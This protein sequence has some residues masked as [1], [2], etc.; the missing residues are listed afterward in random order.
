VLTELEDRARALGYRRLVLETGVHQ[1]EAM[2]LY[3]TSGYTPM[4]PYGFYRNSPLSRCYAKALNPG[5][6]GAEVSSGRRAP[7]G[8][9][10]PGTRS[11]R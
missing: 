9:P 2:R 5:A 11:P 6:P 8:S 1:P 3:E 10:D 7:G 4:E